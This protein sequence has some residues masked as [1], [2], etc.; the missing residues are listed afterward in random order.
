MSLRAAR[1]ATEKT[2][3]RPVLPIRFLSRD[4]RGSQMAKI[5]FESEQELEDYICEHLEEGLN[6]I[7]DSNIDWY[8]RQ[9]EIKPYGVIDLMTVSYEPNGLHVSIE[10]IELKKEVITIKAIAQLARYIR[11]IKH[12]YEINEQPFSLD[13]RGVLVAPR[14]EISDDTVYLSNIVNGIDCYTIDYELDSGISFCYCGKNWG[15][16]GSDFNE[17]E[18]LYGKRINDM[19]L[20]R[21][22]DYKN[23]LKRQEGICNDVV[24]DDQDAHIASV[25]A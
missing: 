10:I 4:F 20:T 15:I 5:V 18:E 21:H 2:E 13:I 19:A 23:Y 25:N 16:S 12:Y 8:G 3:P 7:S 14:F 24:E 1:L 9:V 17:F 6:P 22:V 11:G